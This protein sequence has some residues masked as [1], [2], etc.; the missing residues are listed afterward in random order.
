MNNK[1]AVKKNSILIVLYKN[2]SI[3]LLLLPEL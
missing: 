2:I 1:L 3:L